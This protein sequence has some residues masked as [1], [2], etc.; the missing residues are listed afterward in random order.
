MIE[1][2]DNVKNEI[3]NDDHHM[4]IWCHWTDRNDYNTYDDLTS[5]DVIEESLRIPESI[6]DGNGF[7]LGIANS[8]ACEFEIFQNDENPITKTD[9]TGQDFAVYLF[10]KTYVD[11]KPVHAPEGTGNYCLCAIDSLAGHPTGESIHWDDYIITVDMYYSDYRYTIYKHIYEEFDSSFIKPFR[12]RKHIIIPGQSNTGGRIESVICYFKHFSGDTFRINFK[13]LLYDINAVPLG[14]F[15]VDECSLLNNKLTRKIV[16]YDRLYSKKLDEEITYPSG[17]TVELS[18]LLD[19]VSDV[20]GLDFDLTHTDTPKDYTVTPLQNTQEYTFTPPISAIMKVVIEKVKVTIT[21]YSSVSQTDI[22]FLPNNSNPYIDSFTPQKDTLAYL[23]QIET[24]FGDVMDEWRKYPAWHN[25]YF[26]NSNSAVSYLRSHINEMFKTQPQI[27]QNG[28]F[29]LWRIKNAYYLGQQFVDYSEYLSCSG[30]DATGDMFSGTY[31]PLGSMLTP[32]NWQD[33]SD[34]GTE[35]WKLAHRV[36]LCNINGS[37]GRKNDF[38]DSELYPQPTSLTNM[39]RDLKLGEWYE[40]PETWEETQESNAFVTGDMTVC[41]NV[42]SDANTTGWIRRSDLCTAVINGL[43]L[44]LANRGLMQEYSE[45]GENTFWTQDDYESFLEIENQI[46]A[47]MS[48]AMR[49]AAQYF[50]DMGQFQSIGQ[51]FSAYGGE[52]YLRVDLYYSNTWGCPVLLNGFGDS[53]FNSVYCEELKKC[54]HMDRI[55]KFSSSPDPQ[56]G[57]IYYTPYTDIKQITEKVYT[58]PF[59]NLSFVAASDASFTPRQILAAYA[60][61]NGKYLRVNRYGVLEFVSVG[62]ILYPE[63][64]LYPDD[65]LYPEGGNIYV[66]DTAKIRKDIIYRLDKALKFKGMRIETK[67]GWLAPDIERPDEQYNDDYSIYDISNVIT[68]NF[69]LTNAI[70]ELIYANIWKNINDLELPSTEKTLVLAPWI[71]CGD[72]IYSPVDPSKIVFVYNHRMSGIQAGTDEII[73]K[74]K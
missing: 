13:V 32:G 50:V 34:R 59:A 1:V 9:L 44:N 20:T 23:N 40:D 64:S 63:E 38:L 29:E 72:F 73:Q 24:V 22:T 8:A 25:A 60:E 11:G 68:K 12:F 7:K 2:L 35:A 43:R 67:D 65:D 5:K 66:C 16:A 46:N 55:I 27:N 21:S 47:G 57:Y 19:D 56:T 54:I 51:C 26:N 15:T 49:K 62:E 37:H 48:F 30:K 17:T 6:G 14:I 58:D 28:E 45:E 70:K 53:M 10:N 39:Y 71:E 42:S 52:T 3:L 74:Q 41:A 18:D 69:T 33:E 36:Y 61:L 31:I 4:G